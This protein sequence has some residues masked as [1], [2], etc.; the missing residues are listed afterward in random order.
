M[1]LKK[2]FSAAAAAMITVAALPCVSFAGTPDHST[3]IAGNITYYKYSDHVEVGSAFSA[4]GTVDIQA[5][6]SGLPVTAVGEKA[7]SGSDV[8]VV[9]IPDSVKSIKAGAFEACPL[10]SY[11]VILSAD[12]QIADS[13]TTISNKLKSDG[14]T[15]EFG[16][17][18]EGY[19]SSTAMAYA[20]KYG[21][22]FNSLG[23]APEA[24]TTAT[25]AVSTSHGVGGLSAK[26]ERT[27]AATLPTLRR[28]QSSMMTWPR[29]LL[30]QSRSNNHQTHS[31]NLKKSTQ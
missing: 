14:K 13:S 12:C 10:L 17:T 15:G 18:I 4:S 5:R 23:K 11:V 27:S 30:R 28:N 16:G 2:L 22:T 19:D 7:F 3:V 24:V 1:K 29:T 9:N 26:T 21:Y 31:I 20:K 8:E 25:T 6:I